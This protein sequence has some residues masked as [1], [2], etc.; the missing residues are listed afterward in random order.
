LAT[1]LKGRTSFVIAHRLSTV[2]SADQVLVID[3]G[4]IVERGTH[5]ELLALGGV[6]ADL[7]GRQF[8]DLGP[9]DEK[10]HAERQT[11]PA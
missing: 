8:R 11:A 4:R 1:L 2:R 3:G 7:Y 9:G 5:R 10:S 6:Y